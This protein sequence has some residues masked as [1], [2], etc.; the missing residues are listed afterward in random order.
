VSACL[1]ISTLLAAPFSD[2][3]SSRRSSVM[4]AL[5][6]AV[7]VVTTKGNNTDAVFDGGA[8]VLTRADDPAEFVS[9]VVQMLDDVDAQRE[10][11]LRGRCLWERFFSWPAIVARLESGLSASRT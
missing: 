5:E 9:A 3:V 10:V 1:A 4:A 7:P 6:H 11:G 2:G 8:V